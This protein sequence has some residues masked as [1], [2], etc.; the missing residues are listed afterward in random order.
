MLSITGLTL[1]QFADL[2]TGLGYAGTRSER[3]KVRAP[4]PPPPP[5][6]TDGPVN[7]IP[8]EE[9]VLAPPPAEPAPDAPV[10]MEAFYTF[11]W[12]PKPRERRPQRP[13][14]QA[15]R[16]RGDGAPQGA[17]RRDSG[18][19]GAGLG[20]RRDPA[21]AGAPA[22]GKPRV[23]RKEGGFRARGDK[24][25]QKGGKPGFKG[26]R[27][28]ARGGAPKPRVFESRPEKRDRID[29]DN[30]FAAALMALRDKT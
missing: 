28:D 29:P 8:E 25:F 9:S 1:E 14:G 19:L 24:P 21:Q 10:E 5:P 30:P 4:E 22:D 27:D 11:V 3:P 2:M 26:P 7:P 20:P 6:E 16:P 15:R 13:E 17:P 18:K 12:S 23:E